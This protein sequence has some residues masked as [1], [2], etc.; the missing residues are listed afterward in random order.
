MK[1]AKKNRIRFTKLEEPICS[2]KKKQI[3]SNRS[4]EILF[5]AMVNLWM[6]I[7]VSRGRCGKINFI[8]MGSGEITTALKCNFGSKICSFSCNLNQ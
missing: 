8:M 3:K 7:P 5:Y 4:P 6:V 2:T 1:T